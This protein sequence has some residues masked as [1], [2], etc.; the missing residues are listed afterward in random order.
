M[1]ETNHRAGGPNPSSH[2]ATENTP[3]LFPPRNDTPAIEEVLV[4]ND[5]DSTGTDVDPNEF[6]LMLSRT[7]SFTAI[8]IETN[9]QE[10]SMLRSSRIHHHAK[11]GSRNSS[12]VSTRRKSISGSIRSIRETIEDDDEEPKSPFLGGVGVKRF[13]L[14]FG[15]VLLTYTLS[16]FD[17]TIMVSSHPVITSY[18]HAS[19]SASW[20]STAFLLTSTS[21]QPIFGRLS[22]AMGRKPPYIFSMILFLVSTIWCALAQSMTSFIIARAVC[23]LGA[24]GVMSMGSI[25]TSDLIPIEIRGAYQS[26][27]NIVFG[28]GAASGAALGGAIADHLG[29]RWEFGVQ[30]PGLILCLIVSCFV[31]P[32]DLGLNRGKKT[33][34]EALSVFD[35]KGSLLLMATITFFILAINLGGNIYPWTHPLILTCIILTIIGLP[36]FIITEYYASQPVMPLSLITHNPRGSLIIGNALGA[37]VIN[38]VLFNIPLYFQAVLLESPTASGLRLIIPSIAASAIGTLTGFLITWT[39]NLKTPLVLGVSL[40]VIGTI[41]L[42]A[43]NRSLPNWVYV[44]LLIPSSMGQ[45]FQMPGSFMSVL[46]VSEQGEQAVVTTT[47]VLWRSMGQ[48]LGVAVSSLIVQ[49]SLV[50]FLNANVVGPDKEK[51]IEAVRSSVQAV[52]GLEP[53][54]RDQVIDS[55]AEA[56]KAA[57]VFALVVSILSFAITIGIKL[58]K[59]GFRK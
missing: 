49:N 47:L 10:S 46:A 6:D 33:L 34:K 22:D 1:A 37:I 2:T 31:I 16:S 3:L 40:Y 13:W 5:G 18:F 21:F 24:G 26:Y 28:I 4:D 41:G 42:V 43:M 59:L 11:R 8:G 36:L 12:R 50:G 39:R 20:L 7:T 32:N 35:Y 45:G 29:W 15:G 51:V 48:V 9:P 54:Y 44:L 58:P 30:V 57:Y 53:H 17:S 52:A 56:L 27:L 23:G 38:A 19:N 25:I 14:I 55:Y